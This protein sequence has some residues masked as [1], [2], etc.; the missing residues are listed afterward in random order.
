MA[1]SFTAAAQTY[2]IYPED[3]RADMS[4][5]YV[6]EGIAEELPDCMIPWYDALGITVEQLREEMAQ[7]PTSQTQVVETLAEKEAYWNER[8]LEYSSKELSEI[9]TD[10]FWDFFNSLSSEEQT[11]LETVVLKPDI[12]IEWTLTPEEQ[13][14]LE[15]ECPNSYT[16]EEKKEIERRLREIMQPGDMIWGCRGV[17]YLSTAARGK[18][19]SSETTIDMYN[20][21]I[22]Q[23]DIA[24]NM[25]ASTTDAYGRIKPTNTNIAPLN[26]TAY[27]KV[28]FKTPD[29]KKV[30]RGGNAFFIDKHLLLTAAHMIYDSS[31]G[32][33]EKVEIYPGG[34]ESGISKKV[35]YYVCPSDEYKNNTYEDSTFSDDYGVI[36]VSS[37]FFGLSTSTTSGL[38]NAAISVYGYPAD[39]ISSI[40]NSCCELWISNGSVGPN[41]ISSKSFYHTAHAT[42]GNSGCP[43]VF[44]NNKRI[45]GMHTASDRIGAG[46]YYAL[47]ITSS[48]IEFVNQS[49]F[50][51]L[52]LA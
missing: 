20:E 11:S 14:E 6:G 26:Y 3:N 7:N 5:D 34:I 35:S 13:E 27:I 43:I 16:P 15:R 12:G 36:W 22:C 39:K 2:E 28:Y 50:S 30:G 1:L 32:L 37:G 47:R 33:D 25:M 18:I 48:V 44:S 9:T 19:V 51:S 41:N 8:S 52:A 24:F 17:P 4:A 38:N 21:D 10:E 31:Y 42:S 23:D 46:I 49:K 29:G 40:D 45:A